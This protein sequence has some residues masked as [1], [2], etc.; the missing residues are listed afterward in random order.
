LNRSDLRGIE[1]FISRLNLVTS[2]QVTKKS[3]ARGHFEFNPFKYGV[4]DTALVVMNNTLLNTISFNRFSSKWGIDLSN[5][6]SNGKSLLTYGYESRSLDEW[7]VKSR[8][9]IGQ[10]FSINLQARK[11]TNALYTPQFANRNYELDIYSAEP[12]L[13]FIKG[14]RFRLLGSYKY[15]KK[16][17]LPLYGNEVS[18]S[19][20]FNTEAKYNLLQSASFTGRFTLDNIDY[21]AA[22]NTTVSYIM[23]NGLLPGKNYLWSLGFSKRLM[24]NLELNFQY[25]GRKAGVSNTIHVGRAGLTALF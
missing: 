7:M 19:N 11:G 3:L 9:N 14:T 18:S 25:D 22:A 17:N 4:N 1:K 21:N 20:S 12:M 24:N 10:S 13:V 6:R 15:E 2:L 16:K 5:L 23:L 8:W